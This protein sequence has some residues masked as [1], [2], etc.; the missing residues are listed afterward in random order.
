MSNAAR[1]AEILKRLGDAH[2][3]AADELI[4]LA[5]DQPVT[6]APSGGVPTPVSDDLP[7][8]PPLEVE[9]RPEPVEQ[10][11]L[12]MCPKHKK[13]YIDGTYG[14]Y[15]PSTTDDPAWANKKGYCR[16]TPKN[17]ATYLRMQAA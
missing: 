5:G 9:T 6:A 2:Y 14:P 11:G 8:F 13:P 10:G 15:C 1:L 12:A 16:I 3:Q 4:A 17:V 7:E